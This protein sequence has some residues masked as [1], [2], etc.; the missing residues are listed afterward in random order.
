MNRGGEPCAGLVVGY[1][2]LPGF[3]WVRKVRGAPAGMVMCAG[4]MQSKYSVSSQLSFAADF[5]CG[6]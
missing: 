5:C 3:G 6:A 1:L 4:R 2:S